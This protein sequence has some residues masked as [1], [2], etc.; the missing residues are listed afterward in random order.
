MAAVSE[1]QV[2]AGVVA[3]GGKGGATHLGM[4]GDGGFSPAVGAGAG[5]T[6]GVPGAGAGPDGAS[7]SLAPILMAVKIAAVGR[8]RSS[9]P[10]G[11]I[12]TGPGAGGTTTTTTVMAGI[13]R[14][15]T[16]TPAST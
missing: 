4:A 3:A 5:L 10:A 14:T 11:G 9:R 15:V 6:A 1:A 13:I 8:P 2:P 16:T 12:V 7:R